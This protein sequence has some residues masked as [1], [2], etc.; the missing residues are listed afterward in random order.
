[1]KLKASAALAAAMMFAAAAAN[2]QTELRLSHQWSTGDVRH[3]VAQMIA[4]EVAAADVGL[5]ITIYPSESLFRAREQYNPLSRGQ[6]DMIVYPLSYSGGQ[7]PEYNLTLMPGLVRNHDHAARL[8]ES[9]FMERIEALMAEDDVMVLVHG[10]LAGGFASTGECITR[11]EHVN[12]LTTRAAGRAF[13]EMLAA[14]GASISSMASSEI[15]NAMQTGVL[16]AV[17]TSS[18]SFASFRLQEQVACYTPAGD[19]ALWFMYQ[20]VL[21]NLS[22]FEGLTEEQQAALTAAAANAEAWYLEQAKAEDAASVEVFRDAGVQI[23]EMTE[24]DFNA[25]L[26]LAQESSYPSF[27]ATVPNGQELL[28]LALSVE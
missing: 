26:A 18:S 22:T 28:D 11:P 24:D 5:E 12:G 20:P 8:N 6:V 13:E 3:Q 27:V 15:Y 17:N 21:M 2:A 7:R 4:D 23:A 25:W 16:Q 10:Y 1:M 19:Y 9:P 14:A